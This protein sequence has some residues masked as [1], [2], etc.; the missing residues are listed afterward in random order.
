MPNFGFTTLLISTL[1]AILSSASSQSAIE[2]AAGIGHKRDQNAP[3]FDE[4]AAQEFECDDGDTKVCCTIGGL[5]ERRKAG[6]GL[7]RCRKCM[8]G[9]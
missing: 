1:Y 7:W 2:I 5:E 6:E 9:G 4:S 8:T 3:P